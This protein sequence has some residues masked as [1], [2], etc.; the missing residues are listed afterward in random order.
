MDTRYSSFLIRCW[1][2]QDGAARLVVEH[3]QSGERIV[4][5]NFTAAMRCIATWAAVPPSARD[6]PGAA[7]GEEDDRR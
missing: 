5:S 6:P 7:L 1:S 3:V 2:H 4:V